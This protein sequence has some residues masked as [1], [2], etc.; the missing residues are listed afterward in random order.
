[1]EQLI[2]PDVLA[3]E[4]RTLIAIAGGIAAGHPAGEQAL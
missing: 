2:R 1:L 4:R 3:I